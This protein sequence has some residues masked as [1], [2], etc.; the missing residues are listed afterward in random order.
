M[1]T[2]TL[3]VVIAGILGTATPPRLAASVA[4]ALP[5]R[6]PMAHDPALQAKVE[7]LGYKVQKSKLKAA[8]GEIYMI[9]KSG[10]GSSCSSIRPT[11]TSWPTVTGRAMTI[12]NDTIEAG[13]ATPPATVKVWDLSMRAFHWSLAALFAVAYATGDENEKCTSRWLCDR[14]ADCV[15]ASCGDSSGGGTRGFRF[16][17]AAARSTQVSAR[18]RLAQSATLSRPQPRGR[19]HDHPL[20]AMFRHVRHRHHDDERYL[21]G[22]KWVEDVH[23][24]LANFMVGLIVVHILGVLIASFEHG[25][26]LVKAMLTGRK[27][28]QSS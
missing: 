9:D 13:G 15:Y 2:I 28:R 1:R 19:R 3:F 14:R 18:R 25:E 26:N 24:A 16:R 8:C 17:P 5:L 6:R 7:A 11:A 4:P 23:Q 12:A 20:L 10:A 22:R 27:H 21:L